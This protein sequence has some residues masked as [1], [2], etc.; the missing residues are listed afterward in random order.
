MICVVGGGVLGCTL[1]Y[2]L[3]RGGARVTLLE[4]GGLGQ[5]GASGVPVALL[6]PYRG[7]SARA[8]TFDLTALA[9]MWRLVGELEAQG[10]DTGVRRS[11]VLRVASNRRQAKGWRTREGVRWFEPGEVPAGYHA[12]FGGFVAEAGGWLEPRRWLRAL[13][14]AARARGAVVLEGCLVE[15]LEPGWRLYTTVCTP[16]SARTTTLH[17]DRVVL[18][19][20]S[21]PAPHRAAPELERIAGE[22]IGLQHAAGLPYPLAGAVYGA[23]LRETFYLGGNHRPA[24]QPDERA[25]AQLQ[26]AGG[27]FIPTLREAPLKSVWHGVRAKADDHLPLVRELEP[28]L[29]FAGALAGRGFLAAAQVAE[30]VAAQLGADAAV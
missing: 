30:K 17:A 10:L 11:G 8:S 15:R 29:W 13:V 14:A 25:A 16:T 9:A 6:N 20:G 2:L 18:C 23:Q 28:G 7:R 21:A 22:V 26:R 24:A 3:A 12:P 19:T 4:G 5:G 27:W 1:T